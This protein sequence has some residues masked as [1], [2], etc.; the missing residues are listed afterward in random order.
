MNQDT[1]VLIIVA[2][3]VG[4]IIYKVVHSLT[5]PKQNSCGSCNGCSGCE[6][7]KIKKEYKTN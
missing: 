4:I 3:T 7:T 6:L 2:I 1:I 5:S